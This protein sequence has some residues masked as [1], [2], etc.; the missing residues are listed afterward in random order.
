MEIILVEQQ[1]INM[2]ESQI[3]TKIKKALEE[4]GW[5]VTKLISTSTPGIPDLMAL[6]NSRAVFIECKQPGKK[7]APLQEYR[8]KQLENQGFETFVAYGLKEIASL[9]LPQPQSLKIRKSL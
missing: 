4:D 3:Q 9:F 7:P 2:L 8:I 5:F 1:T 6:K